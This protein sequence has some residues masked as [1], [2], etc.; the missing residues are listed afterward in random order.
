M[1]FEK[2]VRLCG[3]I[4]NFTKS[5]TGVSIVDAYFGP[6][7]LTPDSQRKDTTGAQ[8][9]ITADRLVDEIN[10]TGFESSLR[11]DYLLGE[12]SSL[13]MVVDWLQGG[14]VDYRTLVEGLFHIKMEK[15]ADK[16]IDEATKRVETALS[17][18][19]S[20]NLHQKAIEFMKHGEISGEELEDLIVGELQQKASEVGKLFR[21]RVFARVGAEAIPPDNGVEYKAVKD[22]PWSGYNYYQGGFRSIN[23]FNIDRPFNQDTLRGVIYHE[24]E[25]HVSN[26]WREKAYRE[27]GYL[28]LAV[29][30]LHTG[31]CIISEGTADTA[32]EFLGVVDTS[33]RAQAFQALYELRRMVSINTA[34]LMNAEG[35]TIREAI[36]YSSERGLRDKDSAKGSIEFTKPEVKAGKPNLWAPYVFTYFI[37]RFRFVLPTFKRAVEQGQVDRFFNTVYANPFSCSSL[38]W[39][40]AF[41]WL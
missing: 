25:H 11:R 31:R 1:V 24:Y 26:L 16:E 17:F 33:P 27:R 28:E 6:K 2:Y 29:V 18:M 32:K 39:E 13:R 37:G 36:D 30:P 8:L 7:N 15:F 14:N 20:R 9:L 34:I 12:I 41:D 3:E 23:E 5:I 40:K 35:A 19:K 21:E 22:E 10:N 4:G 38:T